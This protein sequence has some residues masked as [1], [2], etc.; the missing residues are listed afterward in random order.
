MPWKPEDAPRHTHKADTP[1]KK[2]IWAEAANH[3]LEEYGEES[4]AIRVANAAVAKY[5]GSYDPEENPDQN[6]KENRA[7]KSKNQES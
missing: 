5:D 6:P 7:P 4:A 1:H 3:A 2:K